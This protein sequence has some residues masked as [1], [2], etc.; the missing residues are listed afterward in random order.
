MTWW[1]IALIVW[2][3]INVLGAIAFARRWISFGDA[4]DR[5]PIASFEVPPENVRTTVITVRRPGE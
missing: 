4:V 1:Q 3:A 5:S 2:L